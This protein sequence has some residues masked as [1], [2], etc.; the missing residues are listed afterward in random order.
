DVPGVSSAVA[1]RIAGGRYVNVNIDRFAAARY[2][3][4]I[5]DVQMVV[6]GAVGGENIGEV[7]DGRARY[8]INLRYP[9]E[10]RDTLDRLIALPIVTDSGLRLTLGEVARVEIA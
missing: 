8:P 9:R 3:L 6:A 2:G 10:V 5:A 7:I 1:E 4:N